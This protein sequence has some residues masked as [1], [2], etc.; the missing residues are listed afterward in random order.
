MKRTRRWMLLVGALAAVLACGDPARA[1][2]FERDA[3]L[4]ARI[5]AVAQARSE[6]QLATALAE[7]GAA[8]RTKL[9]P[10]L[11]LFLLE[12]E[13]ER[14][15]M[16]PAVIVS[17][18]GISDGEILRAVEP[19]LDA[20]DPALRA[21]L[22]NLLDAVALDEMR[23]L[24]AERDAPTSVGL[25]RYLY[26]RA[27][28]EAVDVV[29]A[30]DASL[31]TTSSARNGDANDA[32][33]DG[34][35]DDAMLAVVEEARR[36]LAAGTLDDATRAQASNALETLSRARDWRLRAYAAAIVAEQPQ[37]TD[38]AAEL[39]SR[40]A[41]DHDARVRAVVGDAARAR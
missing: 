23:A 27:P 33:D 29:R 11:A 34:A 21:Q 9:V 6:E 39:R 15:G 36:A 12:A 20:A 25:V 7:L 5:A 17:R 2:G 16:A 26:R 14:A 8:D 41:A 28:R 1:A 13:G 18:L 32:H 10:Q 22:E 19:Q 24:L 4:Q 30:R 37:L 35:Q 31:A 3:A 38:D 40:L